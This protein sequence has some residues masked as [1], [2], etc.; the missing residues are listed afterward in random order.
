[1]N[2]KANLDKAVDH[3]AQLAEDAQDKVESTLDATRGGINRAMDKAQESV[4]SLRQ[5]AD[6]LLDDLTQRAKDLASKGIDSCCD[7]SRRVQKQFNSAVD[8]T[9]EYVVNQ[10]AKS[11]MLAAIGGALVACVF[12]HNSR[13]QQR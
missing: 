4:Q 7:A 8:T 12:L 6:P 9:S 10:P 2:T 3:A 13:H 11:L 1:M 5:Q